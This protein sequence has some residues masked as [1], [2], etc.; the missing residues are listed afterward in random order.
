MPS[1]AALRLSGSP[2][3][4]Q[5]CFLLFHRFTRDH[6]SP[7]QMA[8]VTK[9]P[10]LWGI[11]ASRNACSRIPSFP[12]RRDSDVLYS[13][14]III[15]RMIGGRVEKTT[16]EM[17]KLCYTCLFIFLHSCRKEESIK[18]MVIRI[19]GGFGLKIDVILVYLTK[20]EVNALWVFIKVWKFV[21]NS[22]DCVA[23]SR[24][25]VSL[26]DCLAMYRCYRSDKL[27]T[28]FPFLSLTHPYCFIARS[29]P[30][31]FSSN[32]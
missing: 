9:S 12:S 20:K 18:Y 22:Y 7:G 19:M 23:L 15:G 29:N 8:P 14:G 26:D 16:P 32:L 11:V 31:S 3:A 5:L 13:E 10:S 25:R 17:E 6:I 27:Q 1:L 21:M 4:G 28:N 2:S 30:T 24:V